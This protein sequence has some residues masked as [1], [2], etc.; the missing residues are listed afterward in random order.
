MRHY[1]IIRAEKNQHKSMT[2]SSIIDPG[3]LAPISMTKEK[4]VAPGS[5]CWGPTF[6]LLEENE[7]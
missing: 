3:L 4:P 6:V 2:A 5:I 1:F 7:V